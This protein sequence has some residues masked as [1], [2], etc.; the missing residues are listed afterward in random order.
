VHHEAF[1]TVHTATGICQTVNPEIGK[2]ASE[3]VYML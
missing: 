2:I 3:C 1:K